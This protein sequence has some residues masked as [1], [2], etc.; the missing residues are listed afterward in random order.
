MPST[1]AANLESNSLG[2]Y[3]YS[4]ALSATIR[5]AAGIAH[6]RNHPEITDPDLLAGLMKSGRG[7][8]Y[9]VL[10]Y[11]DVVEEIWDALEPCYPKKIKDLTVSLDK[12]WDLGAALTQDIL[13]MTREIYMDSE[14]QHIGTE[15][16][17]RA[18][19][20]CSTSTSSYRVL[21][22]CGV[23]LQGVRGCI[24]AYC[25]VPKLPAEL[26]LKNI[27]TAIPRLPPSAL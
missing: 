18:L 10:E 1:T 22:E 26:I 15:H 17:L 14:S 9:L 27:E 3:A 13:R 7:M 4:D 25:E 23:T 19:L 16:L 21:S 8:G 20:I 24:R 5:H 2:Q 11:M 6:M 12:P